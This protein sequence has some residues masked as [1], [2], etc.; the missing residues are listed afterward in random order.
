[1]QDAVPAEKIDLDGHRVPE[2]AEDIYRVPA[3]LV[4]AARWVIVDVDLVVEA[5][6][7]LRIEIRPKHRRK[8]REL[9]FLLR[10]ERLRIIERRA[11]AVAE[12]VGGVPPV[13]AKHPI[14]QTGRQNRLDQRLTRFQVLARNRRLMDS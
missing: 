10:S 12:N 2:P 13:Q 5:A 4:V 7:Q 6:V 11:I 9:C 8:D 1:S 14:A 3:L